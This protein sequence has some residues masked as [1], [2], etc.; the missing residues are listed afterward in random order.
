[1]FVRYLLWLAPTAAFRRC[2]V[3]NAAYRAETYDCTKGGSGNNT[4][5]K[6]VCQVRCLVRH[7][8]IL[9]SNNMLFNLVNSWGGTLLLMKSVCKR[10]FTKKKFKKNLMRAPTFA[11]L[12]FLTYN[13]GIASVNR[14]T[15]KQK[16]FI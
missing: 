2:N 6:N 5:N 14:N 15:W 4:K 9:N 3:C 11:T 12:I 8:C 7:I 13:V 16:M 10:N 1:M